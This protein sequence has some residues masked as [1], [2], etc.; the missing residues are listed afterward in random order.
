M[1]FKKNEYIDRLKKEHIAWRELNF[2]NKEGFFPIF[3]D[4][5]YL[6][7]GLS[8]GAV[9]LFVY[10]GLN[11]N[12]KT[13]EFFHSL[14]TIANNLNRTVRTISNWMSELEGEGLIIR[15]QEKFNGPS[16]TF[17]RPYNV[18]LDMDDF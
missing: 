6:I 2:K 9:N 13:G 11:S 1:N 16:K 5:R 7:G 10:I 18:P 14:E 17:I 12:N 3:E 4:F 8:P 15:V